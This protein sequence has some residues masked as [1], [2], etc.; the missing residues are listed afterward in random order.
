VST[1]TGNGD[2][3]NWDAMSDQPAADDGMEA[4]D[5]IC[6][7]LAD[8]S[9][10]KGTFA[11]WMS[12]Q[13]DDAFCRLAGLEGKKS[14]NCG[15]GA[16]PDP[17]T[18]PWVRMDGH[19]LVASVDDFGEN[20]SLVPIGFDETG[21]ALLS[22]SSVFHG[23]QNGGTVSLDRHCDNWDASSDAFVGF[24]FANLLER[25]CFYLTQPNSGCSGEKSLIC[26]QIDEGGLDWGTGY[27]GTGAVVFV[28]STS[29]SGKFA[30]DLEEG[31]AAA[32]LECQALASGAGLANPDEFVAWMSD[33]NDDAY[34]RVLGLSGKKAANCGV[35][36]LPGSPQ[37]VRVDGVV[38]ATG[39][40]DLT[41]NQLLAP[42]ALTEYGLHQ[43]SSN[44]VWTATDWQGVADTGGNCT[45]WTENSSGNGGRGF[46]A[47]TGNEWTEWGAQG[48][49]NNLPIYCFE[50]LSP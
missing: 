44:S 36:E 8:N 6:Q 49:G 35:A 2:I 34:C 16:E 23:T 39:L 24:A 12:D 45:N 4:A 32:D 33:D 40:A 46:M 48:C 29:F 22:T 42:I 28:S 11:A 13:T 30:R 27:Q 47:S 15:L 7:K 21:V 25:L 38:V 9:G 41:D 10:L 18:G 19:P 31:L 37:W 14:A 3:R 1:A 20:R 17:A 5:M 43:T 50:K 26:F